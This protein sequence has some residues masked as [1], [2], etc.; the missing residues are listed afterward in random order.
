[1]RQPRGWGRLADA[2]RRSIDGAMNAAVLGDAEQIAAFEQRRDRLLL[3]RSR[4]GI[5][6]GGER[7]E[8][9]L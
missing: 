7:G 8:N 3:D 1:M 9:G 2:T 5:A 6:L 4:F